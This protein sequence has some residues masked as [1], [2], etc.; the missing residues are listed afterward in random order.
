MR[1]SS[2]LNGT[3]LALI[4]ISFFLIPFGCKAAE[5]TNRP[6]VIIS[7]KAFIGANEQL[8]LTRDTTV[9]LKVE[10]TD[11]DYSSNGTGDVRFMPDS[12]WT[13]RFDGSANLLTT[14]FVDTTVNPAT[15]DVPDQPGTLRI[16]VTLTDRYGKST[17]GYKLIVIR[18][19]QPP[20]LT[21]FTVDGDIIGGLVAQ[22]PR[23][24]RIEM[25]VEYVDDDYDPAGANPDPMYKPTFLWSAK[26]HDSGVSLNADFF[27]RSTNPCLFDTPD[28][29]GF[30]DISIVV[31]DRDGEASNDSFLIE[32]S[33]NE[34]PEITSLDVGVTIFHVSVEKTFNVTANDPDD[35]GGTLTYEWWSSGGNFTSLPTLAEVTWKAGTVGKYDI[36][37]TVTDEDGGWDRRDFTVEATNAA[38]EFTGYGIDEKNPAPGALVTITVDV[39]DP[40][41]EDVNTSLVYDWSADGGGFASEVVT[42]TGAEAQWLAPQNEGPCSITC[43]VYDPWGASDTITL[44]PITV[45]KEG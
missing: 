6:P 7:I 29:V 25:G 21:D 43:K 36:H 1:L 23:D 30:I 11:E 27:D 18:E 44:P 35:A 39:T 37:V 42:L 33:E 45:E 2:N 26:W 13:A 12:A 19:N 4:F 32:I 22:V 38:P 20:L 8:E 28:V 17:T 10:Y 14:N 24:E 31:T 40:D 41:S 3:L 16:E 5:D 15:F 34:P 9:S